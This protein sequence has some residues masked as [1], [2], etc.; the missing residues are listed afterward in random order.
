MSR[1]GR[2]LL[3]SN[4][5]TQTSNLDGIWKLNEVNNH[6]ARDEWPTIPDQVTGLSVD[7]ESDGIINISWTAPSTNGL[8]ISEYEISYTPSGGS[9][10][11]ATSA[12][13]SASLTSLTN[14]TQYTIKVRAI[15]GLVFGLFSTTA[16]GTPSSIG[17]T[18]L[19][20]NY[21]GSG[22]SSNPWSGS[23]LSD[24]LFSVSG[25]G[26]IYWTISANNTSGDYDAEA[27]VKVN[28]ITVASYSG[29]N[30]I[31]ISG[32]RAVNNGDIIGF[33]GDNLGN[34]VITIYIQ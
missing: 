13:T 32:N 14:G 1:G 23:S 5:P 30:N 25:A 10:L 21:T 17:L 12:T 22:T 2:D 28:S 9:E 34:L 3:W 33:T 31:N 19:A 29:G 4:D 27:Q 11:T 26:T 20:G 7:S 16:Q 6:I 24:S 8:N 18:K 15:S